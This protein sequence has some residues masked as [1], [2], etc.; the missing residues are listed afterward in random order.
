MMKENVLLLTGIPRSGST[1]ATWLLNQT[2]N[3][4][5]LNE[6][7]PVNEWLSMNQDEILEDLT[8]K[9]HQNRQVIFKEKVAVM[10][11]SGSSLPTNSFST[12]TNNEGLRESVVS[13]GE[14][15]INKDLDEDF[16]LVIKHNAAFAAL[17][18]SLI[19]HYKCVGIIR[20]PLAVLL[21]WQ[22]LEIPVRYG[23]TPI[24][25]G[26][27]R[28]LESLLADCSCVTEK[29]WTILNWFYISYFENLTPEAIVTYEDIIA[30]NGR[31]IGELTGKPLSSSLYLKNKNTNPLYPS[32]QVQELTEML[33]DRNGLYMKFYTEK[34]ILELADS[35]RNRA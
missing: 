35:I 2:D 9:I 16:L 19:H 7:L 31:I 4:V 14:V 22:T 8:W 15:P 26:L 3:C 17:L 13:I 30:T 33:L 27:D 12:F 24:G 18:P 1:L 29:Q 20:N 10:K 5:A 11:Q 23:M 25:Q 28:K 6:A 34:Q 32:A 21:S